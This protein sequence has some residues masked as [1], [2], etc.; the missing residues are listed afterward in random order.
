MAK[1]IWGSLEDKTFEYGISK[2]VLYGDL[3]L[4]SPWNGITSVQESFGESAVT[5]TF[6]DSKKVSIVPSNELYEVSVTA[7]TFPESFLSYIGYMSS[8]RGIAVTNKT[9]KVFNFSYQVRVNETRYKIHLLE[10]VVS[11]RTPLTTKTVAGSFEANS[12]TFTLKPTIFKTENNL[13]PTSHTVIDSGKV[14]PSFLSFVENK[15][16]GTST[17]PPEFVTKEDMM[18]FA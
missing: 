18:G 5:E 1:L 9:L 11:V 15:L 16:Y 17:S 7:Y 6:F 4:S 10:K 12:L 2:G 13:R 8:R 14:T 3:G